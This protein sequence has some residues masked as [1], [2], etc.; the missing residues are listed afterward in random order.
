MPGVSRPVGSGEGG[1]LGFRMPS[2]QQLC[3]ELPRSLRPPA[4]C[5]RAFARRFRQPRRAREPGQDQA[6]LCAAAVAWRRRRRR[7]QRCWARRRGR[8]DACGGVA[9]RLRRHVCQVVR[10]AGQHSHP[11]AAGRLHPASKAPT[12]PAPMA[13]RWAA[14]WRGLLHGIGPVERLC[15]QARDMAP[16]LAPPCPAAAAGTAASTSAP[17]SRCRCASAR[18][19]RCAPAPPTRL[20]PLLPGPRCLSPPTT[21]LY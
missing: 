18:G 4:T 2:W 13:A 9:L 20:R 1:Q 14:A 11:G 3:A 19:P 17:R 12:A 21:A 15:V 6:Q 10:P 5:H 7:R 8:G 16:C